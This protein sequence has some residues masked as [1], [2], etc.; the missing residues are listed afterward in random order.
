[1]SDLLLKSSCYLIYYAKGLN[2]CNKDNNVFF[3]KMKSFTK[4]KYTESINNFSK[5][6]K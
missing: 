4:L 5:F 1:M 2:L 6:C 3:N